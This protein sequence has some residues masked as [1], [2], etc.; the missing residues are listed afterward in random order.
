MAVKS[1]KK[2]S[3]KSIVAGSPAI[4]EHEQI[5]SSVRAESAE[6][7]PS[8]SPAA[9]ASG[10]TIGVFYEG[11]NHCY[12]GSYSYTRYSYTFGVRSGSYVN[13]VTGVS[14][15]QNLMYIPT[16][17]ELANMPFSSEENKAAF[18]SFIENDSYLS[19][20]RSMSRSPRISS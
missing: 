6:P 8:G 18:K 7:A 12:V 11:Y 13:D 19:S 17:A 1:F 10:T 9:S 14:G 20:H 16:D 5:M 2:T 15:S 3:K 4:E